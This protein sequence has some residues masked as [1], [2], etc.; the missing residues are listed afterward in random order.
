MDYSPPGLSVHGIFL[1]KNTGWVAISFS[2]G[3][4]SEERCRR[5]MET[6]LSA[7]QRWLMAGKTWSKTRDYD[8]SSGKTNIQG[9][10]EEPE[11]AEWAERVQLESQDESQD[12]CSRNQDQRGA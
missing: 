7:A 6:C 8:R 12:F 10:A 2:K 4:S 9:W 11:P 5:G 1:G 3:W